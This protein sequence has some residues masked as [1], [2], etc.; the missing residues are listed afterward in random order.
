VYST[1]KVIHQKFI[2][3]LS[4]PAGSASLARPLPVPPGA[5]GV[6]HPPAVAEKGAGVDLSPA[7]GPPP[8]REGLPLTVAYWRA[9]NSRLGSS[10]NLGV[11]YHNTPGKSRCKTNHQCLGKKTGGLASAGPAAR[12]GQSRACTFHGHSGRIA[13]P[14]YG[15]LPRKNP[16]V[17]PGCLN[18][19][20][21][22]GTQKHA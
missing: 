17:N 4:P 9:V 8:E 5:K 14:C 21:W 12:S 2:A 15:A 10:A 22:R 20:S 11:A 19:S 6:C 1:F 16:L 7:G 3:P 18:H 13:L